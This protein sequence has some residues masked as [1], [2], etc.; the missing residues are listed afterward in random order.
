LVFSLFSAEA[1]GQGLKLCHSGRWW[2]EEQA[3][4][5]LDELAAFVA[6]MARSATAGGGLTLMQVHKHYKVC[7]QA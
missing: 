7:G 4:H 5:L 2:R 1:T 6:S 3:Q